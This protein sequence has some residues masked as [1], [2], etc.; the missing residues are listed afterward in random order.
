MARK[1]K[2]TSRKSRVRTT[3]SS[4]AASD[5]RSEKPGNPRDGSVEQDAAERLSILVSS[6][7][8]GHEDLLD[9]IYALLTSYGYR[10]VMSHKGTMPV[11]SDDTAM[12]NCIK[13]VEECDLF[14]G[15][16]LPRYGSG[17]ESRD[18]PSITHREMERAI[19]LNKPRWFLVHE[20]VAIARQLLEQMRDDT[21]KPR[22]VLKPAIGPFKPTAVLS[23]LRVIEMLEAAMRNNVNDVA[24][25]RGNWVQHYG[26]DDDARLF[27]TAQFRRHRDLLEK[28]LTKLRDI[29]SVRD[30]IRRD[31]K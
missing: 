14:L 30:R 2:A 3:A 25:R 16:I 29:D 20:N 1:P 19:E 6:A 23:D 22:F 18:A 8:Y 28:H 11:D 21:Q 9:S 5:T 12:A 7:V 17:K 31:G 24:E 26:P 15:V 13:A 4:S 27:V 10:V